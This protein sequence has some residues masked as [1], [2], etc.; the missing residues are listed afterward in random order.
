MNGWHLFLAIVASPS[1]LIA[2]TFIFRHAIKEYI[3]SGIKHSFDVQITKLE[4]DLKSKENEISSL[5]NSV[6]TGASDRRAKL[7][8]RKLEAIDQLWEAT[9]L[10]G[11]LKVAPMYVSILKMDNINKQIEKDSKLQT[12][13]KAISSNLDLEKTN[14]SKAENQRPYL[15]TRAWALFIAYRTVITS[16][17]ARLRMLSLGTQTTD[18]FDEKQILEILK[19]A[20]PERSTYIDS[21][22]LSGGYYLLDELEQKILEEISGTLDGHDDDQK[23]VE[24][25]RKILDAVHKTQTD[26]DRP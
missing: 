1:L 19:V 8:S 23:N 21:A 20:L 17:T 11:A 4:A 9:V 10:L 3:T 14:Y 22:G 6:I 15:T 16:A 7:T 13:F 5:R 2:L 25:T 18:M 24:S 26:M 12:F